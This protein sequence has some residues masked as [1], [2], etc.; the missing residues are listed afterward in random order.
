VQRIII[1]IKETGSTSRKSGS[2]RPRTATTV[3]NKRYVE[4]AIVSQEDNP[5]T[6]KSQRQIAS[7]LNVS[8]VTVQIMTGD[9]GLKSYKRIRVARRDRKIRTKRQ[10]RCRNL[11]DRNSMGM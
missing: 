2:A 1:K 8:L 4:E 5:A 10:T 6:H 9:L 11:N 7:N 3:E